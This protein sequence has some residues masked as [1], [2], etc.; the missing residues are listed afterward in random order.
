MDR[1][2]KKKNEQVLVTVITLTQC[3]SVENSGTFLL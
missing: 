2:Q 3:K 1:N